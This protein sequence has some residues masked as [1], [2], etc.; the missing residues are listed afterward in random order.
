MEEEKGDNDAKI[1]FL[2]NFNLKT[3]N[4][5]P[6]EELVSIHLEKENRVMQ[7]QHSRSHQRVNNKSER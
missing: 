7:Y 2:F 1:A 6:Q 5:T 4:R 3:L